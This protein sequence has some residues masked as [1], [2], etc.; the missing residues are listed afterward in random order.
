MNK[1]L[2]VLLLLVTV[3]ILGVAVVAADSDNA[4]L[5]VS[6][7][8]GCEWWTGSLEAEGS[9]HYVE[10]NNGKWKLSCIGEIVAGSLPEATIH[11]KSTSDDPVGTCFTPFG[12]TYDWRETYTPSGES[13]LVCQGDLTP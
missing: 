13:S 7:D 10:T 8:E 9:V 12:D 4:A 5:V 11:I 1:A 3:M 2:L 6:L